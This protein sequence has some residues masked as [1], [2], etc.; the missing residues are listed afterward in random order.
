MLV[1]YT[2]ITYD[3]QVIHSPGESV[4]LNDRLQVFLV[5][6]MQRLK[7]LFETTASNVGKITLHI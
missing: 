3:W 7:I 6:G 2:D 4:F 1:I 5:V